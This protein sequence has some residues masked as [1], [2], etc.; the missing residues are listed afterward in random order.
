M[1]HAGYEDLLDSF[2]EKFRRISYG[3]RN[4]D[5]SYG[6]FWDANN[7]TIYINAQLTVGPN[8]KTTI[9]N[10]LVHEL[11][12]AL[13]DTKSGHYAGISPKYT[14]GN[15]N[16]GNEY[17]KY[18][19]QPNE[20][21]ARYAEAMHSLEPMIMQWKQRAPSTQEL[22]DAIANAFDKAY[23][24]HMFPEKERSLK[25]KRFFKRAVE[26]VNHE[27]NKPTNK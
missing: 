5:A 3:F 14:R 7:R 22:Y 18:L 23:I 4:M 13:D 15:K 26:F 8:G 27:I 17:T 20:M 10:N 21:S 11:R 1:A 2:P 24:T 12:H 25:Y 19:S 6:G 9:I 16:A